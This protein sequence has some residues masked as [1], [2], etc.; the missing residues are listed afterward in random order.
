M[1]KYIDKDFD[2]NELPGKIIFH[3][4]K[5]GSVIFRGPLVTNPTNIG[6]R[7]GEVIEVNGSNR[8]YYNDEHGAKKYVSTGVIGC[9]CD[10]D[11]D[12]GNLD[13]LVDKYNQKARKLIDSLA[14]DLH[15]EIGQ[16]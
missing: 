16:I 13:S 11:S 1:I 6:C 10:T 9:Y 12:A 2:L 7:L 8:I 14:S 3:A 5:G 15:N 4:T